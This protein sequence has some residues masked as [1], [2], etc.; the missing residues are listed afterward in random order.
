MLKLMVFLLALILPSANAQIALEVGIE[1]LPLEDLAA[2]LLSNPAMIGSVV[3][4]V[5]DAIIANPQET[6]PVIL[7]LFSSR[8]F[9]EGFM[10][11]L[12]LFM[13]VLPYILSKAEELV[14][15]LPELLENILPWIDGPLNAFLS[16]FESGDELIYSSISATISELLSFVLQNS[17]DISE[18]VFDV[19]PLL[20]QSFP[21]IMEIIAEI[22]PVLPEVVR[23]IDLVSTIS[24]ILGYLPALSDLF[25][26]IMGGLSD[27]QIMGLALVLFD[28]LVYLLR[29]NGLSYMVELSLVLLLSPKSIFSIVYALI[30]GLSPGDIFPLLRYL[31][32]GF[33]E[34]IRI[35]I[36]VASY[37]NISFFVKTIVSVMREA[38][39]SGVARSAI[40]E[41]YVVV[42][43]S[44]VPKWVVS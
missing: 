41:N 29:N 9:V 1:S 22:L 20:L 39:Q 34:L 40:S 3:P 24:V 33:P 7:N 44:I 13:D 42:N 28:A 25:I 27:E 19:L 35:A 2:A 32:Y 12:P 10:R 16:V 4:D 5:I 30:S 36:I 23:R 15:I 8:D 43:G 31:L 18:L 38:F 21:D 37:E 26:T 14:V 11:S 17:G 6:L